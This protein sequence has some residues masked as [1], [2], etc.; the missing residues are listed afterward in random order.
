MFLT[1]RGL[2]H[3]KE[4]IWMGDCLCLTTD[5]NLHREVARRIF[6]KVCDENGEMP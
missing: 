2:L 5:E 3:S 1:M 6:K 4:W